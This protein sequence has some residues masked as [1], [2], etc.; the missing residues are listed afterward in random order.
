MHVALFHCRADLDCGEAGERR[1]CRETGTRRAVRIT[2]G[3][4]FGVSSVAVNASRSPASKPSKFNDAQ[5]PLSLVST[6]GDVLTATTQSCVGGIG[7]QT[8]FALVWN[9]MSSMQGAE[10]SVIASVLSTARRVTY[11]CRAQH[12]PCLKRDVHVSHYA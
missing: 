9:P 4:L 7:S 1:R 6:K 5:W 3:A 12:A 2:A 10:V 11:L 8:D